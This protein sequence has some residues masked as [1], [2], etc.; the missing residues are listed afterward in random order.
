M[1]EQIKN[2]KQNPRPNEGRRSKRAHD[3]VLEALKLLLTERPFNQISIEAVAERA[4]VGKQ[5]IYR[6][7]KDKSSL[8]MDLYNRESPGSIDIPDM[9]SLDKELIEVTLQFWRFWRGTANGQAFRHLVA[10]CQLNEKSLD[11]LRNVFMP[12]RRKITQDIFDRAIARREIENG[13]YDF[14]ID[15]MIGFS[16]YHL[17]TNTIDNESVIPAMVSVI[18]YGI[19][20]HNPKRLTYKSPDK[21]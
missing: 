5:T 7:Y 8:F 13:N 11:E 9:D 19:K 1:N 14:L 2:K 17:L 6:W 18:L 15:M 12:K 21:H 20:R 4:G 3:A 16:W 10:T